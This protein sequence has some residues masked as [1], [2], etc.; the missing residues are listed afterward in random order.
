MLLWRLKREREGGDRISPFHA[1]KTK[2]PSQWRGSVETA[3]DFCCSVFSDWHAQLDPAELQF[4]F[5]VTPQGGTPRALPVSNEDAMA[6]L[7]LLRLP[8]HLL[9][10]KTTGTLIKEG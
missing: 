7:S 5:D 6:I 4:Q 9:F 1:P 8:G 3:E 2:D 10:D